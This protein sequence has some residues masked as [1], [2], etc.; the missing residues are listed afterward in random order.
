M[1]RSGRQWRNLPGEVRGS[2]I[3][4]RWDGGGSA[5]TLISIGMVPPQFG[6]REI[7]EGKMHGSLQGF[8]IQVQGA[9]GQQGPNPLEMP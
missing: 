1:V 3:S 5:G 2:P 4:K 7:F 9:E 6:L 8:P